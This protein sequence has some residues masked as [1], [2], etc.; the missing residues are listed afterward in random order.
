ME[1]LDGGP[2]GLCTKGQ[3]YNLIVNAQFIMAV[4]DI[5]GVQA[6]SG[7]WTM[8]CK[9]WSWQDRKGIQSMNETMRLQP[10]SE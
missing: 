7:I 8:G 5:I 9:L 10:V 2:I 3:V 1:F 6:T 4:R